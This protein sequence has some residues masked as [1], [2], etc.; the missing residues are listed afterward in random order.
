VDEV[1]MPCPN[2]GHHHVLRGKG[3]SPAVR[4]SFTL[5]TAPDD[6]L[7]G[8]C[9]RTPVRCETCSIYFA[10]D[11]E[12]RKTVETEAGGSWDS[13]IC[14]WNRQFNIQAL[15]CLDVK[16]DGSRQTFSKPH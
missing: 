14:S 6:I 7:L 12:C 16:S 15:Y 1:T 5:D 2:C 10:V 11:A 8:V 13:A 4:R 9:H 3:S